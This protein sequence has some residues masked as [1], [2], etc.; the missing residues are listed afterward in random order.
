MRELKTLVW[1][2]AA[3]KPKKL[4]FKK[5]YKDSFEGIPAKG[6]EG[7]PSIVGEGIPSEESPK[8][9]YPP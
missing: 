8:Y 2:L 6:R 9:K 5:I 3:D 4:L 7:I 1:R